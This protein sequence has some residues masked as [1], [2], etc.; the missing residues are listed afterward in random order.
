MI[1][2]SFANFLFAIL[3]LLTIS[4]QHSFGQTRVKKVV[5]QAF[6]WDYWNHNYRYSWANYLCE[7]APRL[8]T[9][10]I[11][12]VWIPP[13]S[14]NATGGSVGYSP[15]DL[16][17]LGDKYQKGGDSIRA[18]TRTGSK[19]EL[20]RM[21]AVMHANGIEVIED[22]VMNH[23]SNAGANSGG[24]GGQDPN[25]TSMITESGYKNFRF[26]SYATPLID[27]TQ[28]DY[29]TRA[30]R[31]QKNYQNFHPNP[32]NGCTG[33]DICSSFWGPDIDY[34][35][36]NAIGQSSNIPS[37]GT[38]TV[39]GITRSYYNPAQSTNYMTDGGRSW[40]KW[41]SKQTNVDG[42]RFDAVKHFDINAQKY[43]INEAKY[44]L[45]S[46]AA[47]GE[48]MIS[49]AEWVSSST[50]LDNY[51]S[52]VSGGIGGIG[53]GASGN[54]V[55]G[56]KHTGTYDFSLR[57]Y[58]A[59]GGLYRMV[60]G[61]STPGDFDMSSL[62]GA[63]QSLRY[64]Q[65]GTKRVFRSVPFV[66]S[67]DTYRPKL[68]ATGNFLKP[69][70]DGT[71]WDSGN[72]LGGNGAHIDPR[73]PRLA[74]AYAVAFAVDGNPAAFFEDLLDIGT[75]GKRWSHIPTNETDL[76]IRAEIK[77]IILCHQKLSF[78][79]GDYGVPTAANAPFF[80]TGSLQDHI[81]YERVGK[82]IIGVTDAYNSGSTNAADQQ[83]Y[84]K[85]NDAWAVGTVLYDYSGAHGVTTVTI[86]G[87]RRVLV[88]TAPAGHTIPGAYGHGYSVWAPAP[89]GV[90]FNTVQ[91]IYD[92]LATYTPSRN[93]VT[94]QE[95]EMADDLGDSHCSSLGQGG[96]I[97]DNITNE[98]V[99]GRIFSDSNKV[100]NYTLSPEVDGRNI[101]ISLYNS[102]GVVISTNSGIATAAAPLTGSITTTYKGWIIAKI[103]NTNEATLG[104]K[105]WVRLEYTAPTVVTT[106][107]GSGL[108][109][110][111]TSIW[112]GNKNTSNVLDCGN[113]E[114]GL[115][116]TSTSTVVVYGHAKPYPI[117]AANLSVNK[118]T[119]Y[120]GATMTV[121]PGIQLII[122]S[123]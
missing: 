60:L 117:V 5:L 107:S 104:Q 6:W 24:I 69:L 19:D 67:H 34:E 118:V 75:T 89:N 20:L 100:V 109:S 71:G 38:V 49:I 3:L 77:N 92:Y 115:I 51:M 64:E 114:G 45:P 57:G 66:N 97:P 61:N 74:A 103:R 12:A 95:W 94:T 53:G 11:D 36:P 121:N 102:N 68:D 112:T 37:S 76:P 73:E 101:T 83:V 58:S 90:T 16:Y 18:R 105:A 52:N 78:K 80:Q 47:G 55:A 72:E 28:N 65:Y 43:F 111:N 108:V 86:P 14:K 25:A 110:T 54:G 82:A 70:G 40:I 119:L 88:K 15:F 32:V 96:R 9:L 30:G 113:W 42:Y 1:K 79:D 46:W 98:R 99:V 85:V 59:T 106:N 17:D 23:T 41:F 63:Q 120:T 50:D 2:K 81:V 62:P 91:D 22:A 27:E 44:G 21:I 35:S 8:K 26:V 116:P 48:N 10:G 4:S 56:E 93:P 29:W 39:G 31:W 122:L 33:G 84:C 87:D 7:L 123:Q 13:S